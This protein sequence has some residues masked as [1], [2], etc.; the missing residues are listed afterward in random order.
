MTKGSVFS[1]LEWM[2]DPGHLWS[3][4]QEL[5][6]GWGG[7]VGSCW[8]SGAAEHTEPEVPSVVGDTLSWAV[9]GRDLQHHNLHLLADVALDRGH[10]ALP[11]A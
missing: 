9:G 1:N 7:S 5:G 3:Q 11:L 10:G 8:V 6:V 2:G 4:T